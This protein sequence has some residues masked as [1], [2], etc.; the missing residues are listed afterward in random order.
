MRSLSRVTL[1][2]ML[3]FWMPW[4]P[5]FAS[6]SVMKEKNGTL[7]AQCYETFA[8]C[9]LRILVH[10]VGSWP[11]QQTLDWAGKACQ[12]QTIKLII[13]YERNKPSIAH[14]SKR[15]VKHSCLFRTQSL[16]KKCF[17]KS[18]MSRFRETVSLVTSNKDKLKDKTLAKVPT[19]DVVVGPDYSVHV[20]HP[21]CLAYCWKLGP[22]NF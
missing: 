2:W 10:Q 7:T 8:T 22:N 6:T 4:R 15:S 11:Y 19:L 17:T 18:V 12:W 3:L 9:N 20:R 16:T 1:Y 14:S 5:Y 21:N 13:N